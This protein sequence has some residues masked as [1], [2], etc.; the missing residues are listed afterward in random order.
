MKS[1][2]GI[3]VITLLLVLGVATAFAKDTVAIGCTADNKTA[4]LAFS[5]DDEAIAKKPSIENHI[6][7]VFAATAKHFKFEQLIGEEGFQA[8]KD[9]LYYEDKVAMTAISAPTTDGNS[10]NEVNNGSR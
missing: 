10:C 9:E 3:G 4:A 1:I 7:L 6:K 5:L 2:I 8:F